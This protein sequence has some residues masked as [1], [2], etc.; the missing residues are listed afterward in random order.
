MY[1]DNDE[2]A[3]NSVFLDFGKKW[4]EKK[5]TATEYDTSRNIKIQKSVDGGNQVKN[6][7][8]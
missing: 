3:Q 1:D 5:F 8:F 6:K 2:S 7:H 4:T